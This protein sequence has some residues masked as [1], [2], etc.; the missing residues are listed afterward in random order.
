MVWFAS[1]DCMVSSRTRFRIILIVGGICSSLDRAIFYLAHTP[2]L[3]SLQAGKKESLLETTT[4]TMMHIY[5][6]EDK[7]TEVE[8]AI[9]SLIRNV[10]QMNDILPDTTEPN[11]VYLLQ[12]RATTR[13]FAIHSH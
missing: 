4:S 8:I 2:G 7:E 6:I 3:K 11:L 5:K 13:V 1:F 12:A 10:E 9:R